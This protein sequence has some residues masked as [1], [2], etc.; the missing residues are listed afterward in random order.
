MSRVRAVQRPTSSQ[1][2]DQKPPRSASA[3]PRL[4]ELAPS[5]VSR[6]MSFTAAQALGVQR[7]LD[8][9]LAMGL[10]PN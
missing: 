4:N 10:E 2:K 5:D 8:S 9:A 7:V 1:G 6:M 3:P